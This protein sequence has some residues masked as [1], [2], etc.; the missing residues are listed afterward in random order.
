M[1]ASLGALT[2]IAGVCFSSIVSLINGPRFAVGAVTVGPTGNQKSAMCK[3]GVLIRFI[4]KCLKGGFIENQQT[5][6][7]TFS[8][9]PLLHT[10][11]VPSHSPVLLPPSHALFIDGAV[12]LALT[13]END[14]IVDDDGLDDLINVR[15][16]RHRILA[17]RDGHQGRTE[18]DRQIVGIHHVFITILGETGGART[19]R[20]IMSI[21][22][23]VFALLSW[24]K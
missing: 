7:S 11:L 15:L 23:I 24:N 13:G 10:F 2:F 4:N 1:E 18:A 5:F 6:G 14:L 19:G 16:A 9:P 3:L 17:V 20:G 21:L 12:Q 8:P 22:I